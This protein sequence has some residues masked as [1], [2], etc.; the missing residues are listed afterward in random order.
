MITIPLKSWLYSRARQKL[1]PDT[2]IQREEKKNIKIIYKDK[3][4]CT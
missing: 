1:H 4:E 2:M 3:M